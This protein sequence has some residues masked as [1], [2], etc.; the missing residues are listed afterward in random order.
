MLLKVKKVDCYFIIV[1]D[2]DRYLSLKKINYEN[3]KLIID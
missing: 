1:R 3:F 2:S